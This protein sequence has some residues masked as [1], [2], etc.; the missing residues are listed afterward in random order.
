MK[1]E[2]YEC[3][4][5]NNLFKADY[6]TGVY[7]EP[8]LFL[9]DHY[10]SI[11]PGKADAH[12]CLECYRVAVTINVQNKM[13]WREGEK[14]DEARYN[15]KQQL[16]NEYSSIFKKEVYRRFSVKQGLKKKK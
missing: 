13:N 14:Y 9:K 5:C 2:S 8:D 3:D 10:H 11:E 15:L 1:V 7:N 12:F 16:T 6:T 4:Y